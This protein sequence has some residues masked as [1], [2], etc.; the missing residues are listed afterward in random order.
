M[1]PLLGRSDNSSQT[2]TEK[3]GV[4]I[5]IFQEFSALQFLISFQNMFFTTTVY[6]W[7]QHPV[8]LFTPLKLEQCYYVTTILV[9]VFNTLLRC[10]LTVFPIYRALQPLLICFELAQECNYSLIHCCPF[11]K[12]IKRIIFLIFIQNI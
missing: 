3:L 12:T 9:L 7:R 6:Y 11:F 10:A 8:M 4:H 1:F 2:E 5:Q